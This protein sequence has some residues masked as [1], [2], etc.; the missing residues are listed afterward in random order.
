MD[1][2]NGCILSLILATPLIGA[3]IIALLPEP[4]HGRSKAPAAIALVTALLTFLFTLHLPA[5]Y[6]LS[7]GGFQ[8][9][10]DTPWIANPNIHYHLGVDGLSLWLVVL[11]GL[12]APVGVLASWNSIQE[13]TKL[14]YSLFSNLLPNLSRGSILLTKSNKVRASL[15]FP[16]SSAHCR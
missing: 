16:E 9:V 11:T 4:S 6:L 5:N 10:Q 2:M 8:F 1:S 13:R 3:A 12:L 14:F 7:A 15:C